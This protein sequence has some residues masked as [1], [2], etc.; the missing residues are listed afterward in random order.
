MIPRALALILAIVALRLLAVASPLYNSLRFGDWIWVGVVSAC[1]V[2]I[3]YYTKGTVLAKS[4]EEGVVLALA[5]VVTMGIIRITSDDLREFSLGCG[6]E[7]L[8]VFF[9]TFVVSTGLL[10]TLSFFSQTRLGK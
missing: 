1:I 7:F 4:L 8:K 6:L 2:V 3:Y 10:L 9:P 5:Y